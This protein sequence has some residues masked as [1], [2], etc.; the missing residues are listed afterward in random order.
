MWLRFVHSQC[1]VQCTLIYLSTLTISVVSSFCLWQI[2]LSGALLYSSFGCS[3]ALYW[4]GCIF[5]R[6]ELQ[7]KCQITFLSGCISVCSST[8][9]WVPAPLYLSPNLVLSVI[10]ILVILVEYTT[11]YFH[12]C[13][14]L[15]TKE[16][17]HFLI[18]L[19]AIWIFS[20]EAPLHISCPFIDRDV[21]LSLVYSMYSGHE[22]L[23]CIS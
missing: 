9:V 18:S 11:T 5:S 23:D 12:I 13:I 10:F 4:G 7:W 6:M 15:M 22:S 16:V 17:E 3:Y 2:M 1:C 21:Y 8:G 19:L 14:S 20:C